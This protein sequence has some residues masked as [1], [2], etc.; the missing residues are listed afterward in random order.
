[1]V[2]YP[3]QKMGQGPVYPAATGN[4][5]RS[6]PGA[7]TPLQPKSVVQGDFQRAVGDRYRLERELGNG[8]YG[9]VWR[10]WDQRLGQPVCIKFL[11]P[12][13][14][15]GFALVR[16]KREFWTARRLR[17][18]RCVRA[19]DLGQAEGLWFFSMEY[20]AGSSLRAAA[21]LQGDVGAVVAIALQ[22]LAALDEIHGQ[23]IVHRDIK[24][25]N[26]LLA[27]AAGSGVP[28]A[29][30]TDF[31]VAKVGDLDDNETVRSLRGSPPYLAPEQVTEGI[32]DAR[33]DLY[34]LGVT[35]YQ[36]LS[37][38]HP[39]GDARSLPEWLARIRWQ[40]LTPLADVA[41][42]VPA[43]V[44]AVIM[45]LCAKDPAA[46]Y[47]SAGEVYDELAGW[48]AGQLHDAVAELPPLT[49]APYLAA[50]RL[51]GRRDEQA[52][53]ES[54]LAANLR[55]SDRPRTGPPLLLLSGVAGV[56]KSRLL[57]WLLRSAELHRPEMFI[58]QARSE[59]GAP[60]EAVAPIVRGLAAAQ[61]RRTLASSDSDDITRITSLAAGVGETA[62]SAAISIVEDVVGPR[63]DGGLKGR[64]LRQLLHQLTDRLLR[65]GSGGP[66]LVVIEDLQ[67]SDVET[68]ELL[69]LWTRTVAV[70]RSDGRDLPIAL[71]ATYR[72]AAD[73]QPLST[74]VQELQ[75]EGRAEVIEL[76]ASA[77]VAM[78]EL[79]AELLMCPG[80]YELM[81]ACQ[82]LFGDRP[83]TPL[84]VGQVLRL[85]LS[86][87][88]LR[89]TQGDGRWDFSAL[90]DDVQRLIPET[91]EEA[92][93]E[94][95][96]RL[97]I[98]TKVLLSAAA[99]LGRRFGLALAS[100]T[101]G[102]DASLARD[103]LA[104]AERAGFIAEPAVQDNSDGTTRFVFV[105]DR[106]REALY[107]GLPATQ[108][109]HFHAAAA[110]ALI[111]RSPNKGRD[112]AADLAHHF[113]EAG[114]RT[115]AY[116]FSAL[117]GTRALRAQQF[118]RASELLAQ[119]VEH[120]D[121]LG[122]PV[123]HGLLCR[124]GE[125]A[126]LALHID[127][128]K[129]AYERA[130]T[131]ARGRDRRMNVLTRMGAMY[132][133][134]HNTLGALS[135]YERA[136]AQGLPWHLRSSLSGWLLLA[137][138]LP[139]AM[140]LP[141]PAF[142]WICRLV[143]GR[144]RRSRRVA[145]QRCAW[146]ATQRSFVHGRPIDGSRFGVFAVV[147]GFSGR[148][149]ERGAPFATSAAAVQLA[150]ALLGFA[151]KSLQW[152]AVGEVGGSRSWAEDDR[153][154]YHVARGA[155]AL[156]LAREPAAVQEYRRVFALALARK[157][158]L[159]IE[160]A[161]TS[162]I[163][164]YHLFGRS[165]EALT[166][167]DTVRRFAQ[168]ENY[169]ALLPMIAY[170]E[171]LVKCGR[172]EFEEAR[173]RLVELTAQAEAVDIQDVLTTRTLRSVELRLAARLEGPSEALGRR[174]IELLRE[175][176]RERAGIPMVSHSALAFALAVEVWAQLGR[177]RSLPADVARQLARSRRRLRLIDGS[178]PW[179][180]PC[181]L[182]SYA[183]Y[184]AMR[185]K[186]GL[187]RR[188]LARGFARLA[189]SGADTYRVWLCT[190][191]L[192]VFAPG[193]DLAQRCAAEL[194]DAVARRPDLRAGVQR[195]CG[196]ML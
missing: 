175:S 103:C 86:R 158:S 119:A 99:V 92:I 102:L 4:A 6:P 186:P 166:V 152:T 8:G 108:R 187:A 137:V 153:Y 135:V 176:E 150:A 190:A 2:V 94:R 109:Q 131:G 3:D 151:K 130:L 112:V 89:R 189:Q 32:A 19:F 117:A 71:V 155:A 144:E 65:A 157:D 63:A 174:A 80:D 136:L 90:S 161:A 74:L 85:L 91:V 154:I 15:R 62:A 66:T 156:C 163:G 141:P 70:D 49:R 47:R 160:T 43:A 48:L 27:Q 142:L 18:P 111:A 53:I 146:A 191:G 72:P 10:A 115:Q 64:S 9:V 59:I 193:S 13:L 110:A 182:A 28:T 40:E 128:A 16:F 127:R 133:R 96:A 173:A 25:H 30:L 120:A 42:A 194:H 68:V 139:L 181:W 87:G 165:G 82:R 145:L 171:M 41:P 162:L 124:L 39:L 79:A 114:D 192:R 45:K 129:A 14:A 1:V 147:A 52:R 34:S 22:I 116:R 100:Q 21:H 179:R 125:A 24:P 5:E 20:I 81:G 69:K 17:H 33:S 26:I 140:I 134:A 121:R 50:P 83:V 60:F 178:G 138:V 23:A 58:G 159:L 104:E 183:L 172:L 37:G 196:P 36:V 73:N 101:A 76:G 31:G 7:R 184:D 38:R 84:Y 122:K 149:D 126:A 188:E 35:L 105:H 164:A 132:D 95:A 88:L 11:R 61:P 55:P 107:A 123:P 185:G 97:S 148:S 118:S 77:P 46:R 195:D 170:S 113:Q 56:G 167:L 93:G 177:G 51:I 78:V 67:W 57:S 180:R 143:L 106:L 44:T 169:S 168:A 98:D 54:F 75:S 29:K 12:E